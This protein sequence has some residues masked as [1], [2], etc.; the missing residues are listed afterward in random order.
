M[1]FW[2]KKMTSADD[3]NLDLDIDEKHNGVDANEV[4]E[5]L[6]DDQVIL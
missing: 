4:F 2:M 1:I 3:A 5:Q 6:V